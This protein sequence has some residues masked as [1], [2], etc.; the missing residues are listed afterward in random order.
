GGR[1]R[2]SFDELLAVDAAVAAVCSPP[3]HHV[4]QAEALARP[5]RLVFVEKPVATSHAE[6]A[7]LRRVPNVVPVLQWRAGRAARELRA[8]LRAG[9][10]GT[11]PRVVCDLRLWRDADYFAGGRRGRARWG[12]GAMLSIGVHAVDLVLWAV[13]RRVLRAEG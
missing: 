13:E 7:R 5:G 3:I 12:C 4:E 11:R 9:A 6:L 1:V 10:F 2:A 8:A